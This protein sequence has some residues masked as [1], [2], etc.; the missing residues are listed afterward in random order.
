MES[1]KLSSVLEDLKAVMA[2]AV[3]QGSSHRN[4]VCVSVWKPRAEYRVL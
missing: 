4:K 2:A 3:L 1:V